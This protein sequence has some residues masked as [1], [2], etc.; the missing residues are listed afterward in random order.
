[1]SSLRS[2]WPDGRNFDKGQ[3]PVATPTKTNPQLVKCHQQL[4]HHRCGML[5]CWRFQENFEC[6]HHHRHNRAVAVPYAVLYNVTHPSGRGTFWRAGIPP[7][8]TLRVIVVPALV[9][10]SRDSR[11]RRARWRTP[12]TVVDPRYRLFS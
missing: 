1:M 2:L 4:R 8:T 6:H 7:Q 11:G 10:W 12:E 9:R 5:F 3:L